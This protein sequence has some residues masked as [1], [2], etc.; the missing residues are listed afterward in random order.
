MHATMHSVNTRHG[1]VLP[2][3]HGKFMLETDCPYLAPEP[4]RG[5]VCEPAHVR[6]IAE[7][8]AKLRNIPLPQLATETE[9]TANAFF[10]F[11]A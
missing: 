1:S 7:Q 8:I 4:H 6:Q 10:P 5:K 11:P 9:A 3:L 2:P